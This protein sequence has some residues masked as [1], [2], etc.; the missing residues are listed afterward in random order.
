[1]RQPMVAGNWKMNGTKQLADELAAAALSSKEQNRD[2]EVVLCPPALYIDHLKTKLANSD[3]CIGA[4]NVS[5]FDS[6]AYTGELA[7]SMLFELGCSFA[8]VG[9]SERRQIFGESNEQVAKKF[10]AA[11]KGGLTPILC[12]GETIEQRENNETFDVVKSQIDAVISLLGISTLQN[13]VLAYEPVWAIGTGLTATPAQAQE[14]HAFIRQHIAGL[15]PA[16]AGDLRILYGG[17][18]KPENAA[19]LFASADIDGGLIGGASLKGEDFDRICV[20]AQS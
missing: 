3:V 17:S 7:S 16:I 13:A 12:I 6:G 9:H 14:V 20:A 11:Q 19:E 18:V 4:Q 5:E 2:V 1:M 8:I 15:D 10:D